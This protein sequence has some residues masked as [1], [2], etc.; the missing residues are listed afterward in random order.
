M[1]ILLSV[2]A[3][4]VLSVPGAA[5]AK[6]KAKSASA[7]ASKKPSHA[8]LLTVQQWRRLPP[9]KRM[10]YLRDIAQVLAIMEKAQARYEYAHNADF[11]QLKEYVAMMMR[12]MKVL[13]EAM[14]ELAE[15][16]VPTDNG[17]QTIV[18]T[19]NGKQW[20][21]GSRAEFVPWLHTCIL[22]MPASGGSRSIVQAGQASC[23]TGST[24][25]YSYLGGNTS[26]TK[27][28]TYCVPRASW[29][30]LATG[31]RAHLE[32]SGVPIDTRRSELTKQF[33]K[34]DFA[35][36]RRATY[37]EL[38][39]L[40]DRVLP[41]YKDGK[42]GCN[43][44]AEFV[45]FL[46]TCVS[47]G[48]DNFKRPTTGRTGIVQCAADEKAVYSKYKS[49]TAREAA[50]TFCIP[51]SSWEVLSPAERAILEKD[52][53]PYE[54][55]KRKALTDAYAALDPDL[56]K[57]VTYGELSVAEAADANSPETKALAERDR[58]LM[59]YL[60][61]RKELGCDLKPK[62]AACLGIEKDIQAV[63]A[64][65][66]LSKAPTAEGESDGATG[67]E[68]ASGTTGAEAGTGAAAADSAAPASVEEAGTCG[69]AVMAC[70]PAANDEER[71]QLRGSLKGTKCIAAGFTKEYKGSRPQRG[72][73]TVPQNG[74]EF[75]LSTKGTDIYDCG[76]GK[77][78]CNPAAFCAK[79]SATNGS[80]PSKSKDVVAP[81]CVSKTV[82]S[83][84][85]A[86][87]VACESR[88][89]EMLA[90]GIFKFKNKDFPLKKCDG[91]EA[92]EGLFNTDALKKL[93]ADTQANYDAMC[94]NDPSALKLFCDECKVLTAKLKDMKA[95]ACSP[96]IA[97]A[98]PAEA[99]DAN[100]PI[101]QPA[102]RGGDDDIVV[103]AKVTN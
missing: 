25:I 9:E 63:M 31:D 89:Q 56:Q 84:L 92:F 5:F 46:H 12:E 3:A 100:I 45:P 43:G 54:E 70:M 72:G 69:E 37:G 39:I 47:R 79:F 30:S 86:T 50:Q 66:K 58:A 80:D 76:A 60:K 88:Y 59:G 62:S 16:A 51:N 52:G 48:L 23:P 49:G 7:V 78:L 11:S 29:L 67:A 22:L 65:P 33:A 71:N 94:V 82:G 38:S 73:C 21:C 91:K 27:A 13:P 34:M 77:A 83:G 90:G 18:P 68:G 40:K 42:W 2:A 4:M 55:A 10:K 93:L 85:P 1:R 35:T 17:T 87:T 28:G 101:P 19:H 74:K 14:A 44:D 41:N 103:P 99:A 20:S 61:E 57:R 15:K 102:D 36:Q 75:G 6:G 26:G 24:A 95:L 32:K 97:E 96:A 81:V 64:G 8:K 53:V 98:G